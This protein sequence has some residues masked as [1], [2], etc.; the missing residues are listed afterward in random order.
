MVVYFD[1]ISLEGMKLC[2]IFVKKMQNESKISMFREVNFFLG[3]QISHTE[4]GIFIS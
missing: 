3:L 2:V 4:K 1:D